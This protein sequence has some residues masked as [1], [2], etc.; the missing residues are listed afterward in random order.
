MDDS[1]GRTFFLDPQAPVQRRYEAI[2]AVVVER[3]PLSEVAQRYGYAYGTV[4]NLV[5]QFH[6]QCRAGQVPPFLPRCRVDDRRAPTTARTHR[7]PQRRTS[8]IAGSC[9]SVVNAPCV[10]V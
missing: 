3:Q 6:A 8:P 9:R 10:H 2:R 7:G 1:L 4:R 5:S